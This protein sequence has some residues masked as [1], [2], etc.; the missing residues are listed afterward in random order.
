MDTLRKPE[1]ELRNT[2][3]K[4][5]NELSGAELSGALLTRLQLQEYSPVPGTG[6]PPD[7]VRIPEQNTK[8]HALPILELWQYLGSYRKTC[9]NTRDSA[10]EGGIASPAVAGIPGQL[11]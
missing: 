9:R 8:S 5:G 6:P 7:A 4:P 11:L 3:R 2:L 10:K 1:T